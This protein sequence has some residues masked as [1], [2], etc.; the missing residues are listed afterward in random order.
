M[1]TASIFSSIAFQM[2]DVALAAATSGI[3][4]GGTVTR[5]D[6]VVLPLR[7]PLVS[8]LP[9]DREWLRALDRRLERL[10]GREAV[11]P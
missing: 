9:S 2:A 5:V 1:G 11:N 10:G 4:A 6:G 3:D 8:P 7:P